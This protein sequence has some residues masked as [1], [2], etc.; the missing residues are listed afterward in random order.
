MHIQ[1]NKELSDTLSKESM[2]KV[3]KS[4]QAKNHG[5]GFELGIKR[6]ETNLD[7]VTLHAF[8]FLTR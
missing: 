6:P 8:F 3:L 4:K 1:A 2:F 5:A 7:I